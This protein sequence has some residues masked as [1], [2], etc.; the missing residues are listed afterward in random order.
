MTRE[1]FMKICRKYT[2]AERVTQDTMLSFYNDVHSKKV[3]ADSITGEELKKVLDISP[4]R[5]LK[6]VAP[7]MVCDVDGFLDCIQDEYEE[8]IVSPMAIA[9]TVQIIRKLV[10]EKRK[11][12]ITSN[13]AETLYKRYLQAEDQKDLR[14]SKDAFMRIFKAVNLYELD[15][16]KYS[17]KEQKLLEI[18]GGI[19]SLQM[20]R[21]ERIDVLWDIYCK[22]VVVPAEVLGKLAVYNFVHDKDPIARLQSIDEVTQKVKAQPPLDVLCELYISKGRK[23]RGGGVNGER[24]YLPND[25][26]L[27]NGLVY[28]RFAA[29]AARSGMHSVA[30]FFPTPHFIR[31]WIRDPFLH[32]V[33][34]VFVLEDKQMCSIIRHHFSEGIHEELHCNAAFTTFEEWSNQVVESGRGIDFNVAL[35]FGCGEIREGA[36]DVGTW[37]DWIKTYA[38][39]S[40][41]VFA[42][43]ASSEM[44]K[45]SPPFL[46]H[47]QD[48]ILRLRTISLIPQG[49]NNS[50]EPHRKMLVRMTYDPNVFNGDA[51]TRIN[52]LALSTEFGVQAIAP[53]ENIWESVKQKELAKLPSTLRKI[54]KDKR[55]DDGTV[56]SRRN[57]PKSYAFTPDITI[58]YS[59]SY[60]RNN[61]GRPRIEAYICKAAEPEKVERGF[62]DRDDRIKETML[63]TTKIRAEDVETW[64]E[65]KYPFEGVRSQR[66]PGGAAVPKQEKSIKEI[67]IEHYVDRLSGQNIAIKTMWYLWPDSERKIGAGSVELLDEIVRTELGNLRVRDIDGEA[68]EECLTMLFPSD[69]RETLY[70]R[71]RLLSMLLD[72]AVKRGHCSRNS[73]KEILA[74]R[75]KKDRLFEQVRRALTKKHLTEN[76]LMKVFHIVTKELE[77]GDER[78]LGVLIRMLTGL[79]GNI[80][81]ALTCGDV[82]WVRKYDFQKIAITRQVKND[83]STCTGFDSVEDYRFIPCTVLMNKYIDQRLAKVKKDFSGIQLKMIP[84]VPLKDGLTLITPVELSRL[85]KKVIEQIGIDSRVIEVPASDGGRKETNLNQYGGDFFRE[86]FRYWAKKTALS[87]DELLFLMGNKAET[88]LGKFYCDFLNDASLFIMAAKLQRW[89]AMFEGTSQ[90]ACLPVDLKI[91]VN[92]VSVSSKNPMSTFVELTLPQGET[93]LQFKGKYGMDL[94]ISPIEEKIR[95]EE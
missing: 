30:V 77:A 13:V 26:P 80:V 61:R 33:R 91:G 10:E 48:A 53:S 83:G 43:T 1:Q 16:T 75:R 31:K 9:H 19:N 3:T 20:S 21:Q 23:S 72:E 78:Y 24:Y 35:Y 34:A 41:E 39:H 15:V 74:D 17:G 95:K 84:L 29:V 56:R 44:E 79:E 49:I 8:E 57:K 65:E 7:E 73:L 85:C 14:F 86:N 5:F 70:R 68:I 4:E 51:V 11:N 37:L 94:A 25:V 82:E 27:E 59:E 18:V 28:N 45:D 22:D 69:T 71:F 52:S 2:G 67:I 54:Y 50:S 92:K 64:L 36:V 89:H 46:T 66:N 90:D 76:E 62:M 47:I 58:W 38:D 87:A 81:C 42:L 40:V 12:P 93:E 63:V 55:E 32:N 6:V 60:P 88:T